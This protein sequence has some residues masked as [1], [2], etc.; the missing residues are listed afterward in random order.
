MK[1]TLKIATI[2]LT[3][4]VLFLTFNISNLQ[5]KADANQEN[6]FGTTEELIEQERIFQE[7]IK[8]VP[9]STFLN[10]S[11]TDNSFSLTSSAGYIA[12]AGD[13]L[14]TP[15]TQCVGD[16]NVCLGIS[17]HVGIVNAS[18]GSVTHTA[19]K[20]QQ[21]TV[22]SLT[23]WFSKYPQTIVVR[24]K[25]SA[26]ALKAATWALNYYGVGGTGA[27]KTYKVT[28]DSDL[29]KTL[30]LKTTYCSL[31]VWQAYYFGA[32]QY[33]SL[34]IPVHPVLFVNYAAQHDMYVF[35]KIGY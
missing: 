21:S 10:T 9:S 20:G 8:D 6:L 18:K 13:V 4:L 12:Q 25:D 2:F 35:T 15:S 1:K 7:T 33:L 31:L 17:G 11:D 29:T 27:S 16:Q 30:S 14:F 5:V 22:I 23:T 26:K 3:T 34:N 24:H 32:N 19:G 28:V